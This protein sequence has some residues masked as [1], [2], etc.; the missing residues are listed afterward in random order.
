MD[1]V[2]EYFF[3]LFFAFFPGGLN[4]AF[5]AFQVALHLGE[6]IYGNVGTQ[7][8]LD[9]TATG[10]AVGLASR[11]EGLTR[12]LDYSILGTREFATQIEH[13]GD[14]LGPHDI[15]GF[16]TPISLVGFPIG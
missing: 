16:D 10:P 14:D 4:G 12:A 13:Q 11:I 6:V 8:R 15:R 9:F 7:H 2:V 3:Y 1:G 5:F